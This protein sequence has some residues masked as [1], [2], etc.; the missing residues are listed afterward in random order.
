MIRD[1]LVLD[2]FLQILRRDIKGFKDE[3]PEVQAYLACLFF[4]GATDKTAHK[5]LEGYLSIPYQEL[6][7]KLGRNWKRIDTD[8][9]LFTVTP[10]WS[11]KHHLTRGIKLSP[12]A[13]K[14]R[15]KGLNRKAALTKVLDKKL[16]PI[17]TSPQAIGS[18]DMDDKSIVAWKGVTL[19][20]VVKVNIEELKNLEKKFKE[21]IKKKNFYVTYEVYQPDLFITNSKEPEKEI[22]KLTDGIDAIRKLLHLAH[23]EPAGK[24]F[25][26]HRYRESKAGRLYAVNTNLQN[27]PK[28]VKN[29]AL[30]GKWEYDFENCHY[31]I[32]RQMAGAYQFDCPNIDYY[33]EN[34]REVRNRIAAEMGISIDQ[35][36]TCLL[37]IM[38]G[39]QTSEWEKAAIPKAIGL[40]KVKA[41]YRN[42][43][44]AGILE[45]I[46]KGRDQIVAKW[47]LSKGKYKNAVGKCIEK[48]EKITRAGKVL[49][50]RPTKPKKI[51][52]HL[53][54]GIEAKMLRVAIDMYSDNV[55][56]VQHDGFTT[57]IQINKAAIIDRI[58]EVT[59]M[60]M[61]ISEERLSIPNKIIFSKL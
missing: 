5:S 53:I 58:K 41:L 1:E 46:E 28:V 14:L 32:F 9:G 48:K 4:E 37:A 16:R 15:E 56:L 40:G 51:L 30:M 36:K 44:F 22:K 17:R 8:L 7:T 45:D 43:L 52:A 11:K 34:K 60:D 57:D 33:L 12:K 61:E 21:E 6:R 49:K 23:T 47:P 50:G 18:K 39:A 54:Q 27:C 3:K 31:S 2:S 25:I 38:Y 19:P 35:V 42:E 29:V 55:L 59:G 26:A 24:D 13:A 20:N 10:N